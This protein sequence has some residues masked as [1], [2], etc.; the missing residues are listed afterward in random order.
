VQGIPTNATTGT[1][2]GW[3]AD[4][5]AAL[6][7]SRT[8]LLIEPA[9]ASLVTARFED[10]AFRG[11]SDPRANVSIAGNVEYATTRGG[12][13]CALSL[14]LR[15]ELPADPLA[16]SFRAEAHEPTCV[17]Y[18]LLRLPPVLEAQRYEA[19]IRIEESPLT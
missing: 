16:Y 11:A 18:R 9:A 15:W 19:P 3:E 14:P 4:P 2:G 5:G 17:T 10:S 7:E 13:S 1:W 8:W 6:V 12:A